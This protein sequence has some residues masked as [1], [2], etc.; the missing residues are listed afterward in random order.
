MTIVP[1][2]CCRIWPIVIGVAVGR[3]GLCHEKPEP[4][5]WAEVL[6]WQREQ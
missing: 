3:C 2:R 6:A 4:M 5:D 1:M